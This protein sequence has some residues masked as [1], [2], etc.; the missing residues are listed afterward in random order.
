MES[1]NKVGKNVVGKVEPKLEIF[2]LPN[3]LLKTFQGRSVLSN[4]NENFLTP[5]FPI[6]KFRTSRFSI[7]ISNYMY[8]IIYI[9]DLRIKISD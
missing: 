4:L 6:K 1:P 8:P 2:L 9:D 3:T 5:D 7:D